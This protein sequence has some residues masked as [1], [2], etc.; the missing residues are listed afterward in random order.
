MFGVVGSSSIRPVDHGTGPCV[1]Q[2]DHFFPPES[3]TSLGHFPY[4]PNS[5]SEDWVI[6]S[7]SVRADRTHGAYEQTQRVA[8][9]RGVGL[10]AR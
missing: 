7:A 2:L 3:S 9:R 10:F 6:G 8:Q 4:G 1:N 5:L